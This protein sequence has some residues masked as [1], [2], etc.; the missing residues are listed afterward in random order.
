LDIYASGISH[1]NHADPDAPLKIP[2]PESAQSIMRRGMMPVF[3]HSAAPIAAS[4]KYRSFS[5]Y[6][7][8]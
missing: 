8:K 7:Y 3:G 1:D 2:A 4:G 5:R 6:I